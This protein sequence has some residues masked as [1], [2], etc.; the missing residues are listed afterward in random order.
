MTIDDLGTSDASAFLPQHPMGVAYRSTRGRISELVRSCDD[1]SAETI[2][3]ACPDWTV[4]QLC[5]H[6]AGVCADLVAGNRP[7]RD[8]QRGST[9]RSRLVPT[10]PCSS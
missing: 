2:V 4:R 6:L 3:P 5:S 1:A 10:A 7:A 9:R 8:V